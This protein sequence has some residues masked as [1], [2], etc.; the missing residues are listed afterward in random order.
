M[1]TGIECLL[2]AAAARLFEPALAGRRAPEADS[3]K[4]RAGGSRFISPAIE[5][6]VQRLKTASSEAL[7]PLL[8]EIHRAWLLAS[9]SLCEQAVD[10]V[11]PEEVSVLSDRI[12]KLEE[13]LGRT[14][15]TSYA[16]LTPE[17][18]RELR[19]LVDP[20]CMTDRMAE[21]LCFAALEDPQTPAALKSLVWSELWR[22]MCALFARRLENDRGLQ[23]WL[24]R[25]LLDGLTTHDVRPPAGFRLGQFTPPP[26]AEPIT[27][28]RLIRALVS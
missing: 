11:R 21:Q 24:E 20:A 8:R 28:D 10:A 14:E 23:Q 19:Y 5:R 9:K 17:S 13:D 26:P 2:L 18:E 4:V 6:A 22:R 1:P 16:A 3:G 12:R 15:G 27:V 7:R 25:Y